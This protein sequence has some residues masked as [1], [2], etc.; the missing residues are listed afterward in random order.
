M[1]LHNKYIRR[2]AYNTVLNMKLEVASQFIV[3][4]VK[5]LIL[6]KIS[7]VVFTTFLVRTRPF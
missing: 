5:T 4:A 3:F 2:F 1:Y 6:R 7:I